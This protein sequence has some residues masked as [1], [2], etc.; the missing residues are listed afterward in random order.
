M[1]LTDHARQLY[2]YS[3]YLQEHWIK[4]VTF[5][6][7]Q[8]KKG[9]TLDQKMVKLSIDTPVSQEFNHF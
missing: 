8:T 5:L 2:P 7:E 3:P 4:A 1:S 9:W 6:R